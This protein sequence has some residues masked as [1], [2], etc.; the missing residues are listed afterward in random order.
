MNHRALCQ[1]GLVG[2]KDGWGFAG[3]CVTGLCSWLML[4]GGKNGKHRRNRVNPGCFHVLANAILHNS[5]V[6]AL[7]GHLTKTFLFSEVFGH[8]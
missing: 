1:P 6:K 2:E 8:M 4:V 5:M 7:G 3:T